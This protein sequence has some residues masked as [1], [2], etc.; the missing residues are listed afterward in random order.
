MSSFFFVFMMIIIGAVIGGITNSLAIKMLFRPHQAKYIGNYKIPFTPGLIPKRR[1]ELARQ[2]GDVVVRH[3]LTPDG[4]KRRFFSQTFRKRLLRW[5]LKQLDSFL[6]QDMTVGQLCTKLGI[7]VHDS[8]VHKKLSEIVNGN[9]NSW[10][11]KNKHTMLRE[12]VPTSMYQKGKDYIPTISAQVLLKVKQYIESDSGKEN[13]E[14]VIKRYMDN[15]GFLGNVL[16]SFVG[17]EKLGRQIQPMLTDYISST[18]AEQLITYLLEQQWEEIMEKEI[19][20]I[21]TVVHINNDIIRPIIHVLSVERLFQTRVSTLYDQVGISVRE[22]WIPQMLERVMG[23]AL[24]NV[25]PMMKRMHIQEIVA[26]EV[27]G[28]PIERIE[29]MVL[30]ITGRELRMITYLGALLGGF[31]GFFQGMT[32]LLWF[33]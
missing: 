9:V 14:S 23:K 20:E 1:E 5:I 26:D 6:R 25:E 29:S 13:I 16:T 30:T 32:V 21:N 18:E 15:K 11:K 19:Q 17:P 22:K 7:Q 24:S 2:M 10:L 12:I 3:L 4:V 31:I 28:F 27:K 8:L 33:Q